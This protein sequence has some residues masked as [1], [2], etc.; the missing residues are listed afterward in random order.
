MKVLITGANGYIGSRCVDA[1][2]RSGW[3]VLAATRNFK[4][5]TAAKSVLV[6]TIDG[7]SNWA[8]HLVNVDTV[9]HLAGVAHQPKAEPSSYFRVN[10][11]GTRRLVY[12]AVEAGVRRFI[13]VS[14]IAVYGHVS[15]IKM[16]NDYTKLNPVEPYGHSKAQAEEIIAKACLGNEM[17]W[18]V[19]RPPL[20]YG[21]NAPG[22]FGRLIE[23][24]RRRVPL[25]LAAANA[26]RSYIGLENLVSALECAA[27]HPNAANQAFVIS[28]GQ[29]ICT[30]ELI[31]VIARE[32]DCSPNLWWIPKPLLRVVASIFGR[33]GEASKLLDSLQIDS[34]RF[35]NTLNWQPPVSL[36]DGLSLSILNVNKTIY[37]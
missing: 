12:Q 4:R 33:N 36:V 22:N 7:S 35:R 17:T 6:E 5:F 1:F 2:A 20:V 3:D 26:L 18:T 10:V 25:P 28:D 34:S 29:E 30:A 19:L 11:D 23:L 27:L 32:M 24:V 37:D 31:K 21:P 15:S 9:I 8:E 13:F 14:S 16:L